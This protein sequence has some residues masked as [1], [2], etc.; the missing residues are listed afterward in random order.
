MARKQEGRYDGQK[1][2][3]L[4]RPPPIRGQTNKEHH[5]QCRRREPDAA[6]L[7]CQD[8]RIQQAT[9]GASPKPACLQIKADSDRKQEK[10]IRSKPVRISRGAIGAPSREKAGFLREDY[11]RSE[12]LEQSHGAHQPAPEEETLQNP[13][14]IPTRAEK[15]ERGD[16]QRHDA[17]ERDQTRF[18]IDVPQQRLVLTLVRKGQKTIDNRIRDLIQQ[19]LV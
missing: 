2:G 13:A 8:I 12:K 14:A 4:K 16:K 1:Q 19:R 3:Q 15:N 9:G 17:T 11:V 10:Q 18:A 5:P 7:R 6:G